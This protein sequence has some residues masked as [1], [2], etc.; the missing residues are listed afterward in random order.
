MSKSMWFKLQEAIMPKS[1]IKTM[2]A[3]GNAKFATYGQPAGLWGVVQMFSNNDMRQHFSAGV[4]NDIRGLNFNAGNTVGSTTIQSLGSPTSYGVSSSLVTLNLSAEVLFTNQ[5]NVGMRLELYVIEPRKDVPASIASGSIP[6]NNLLGS[7]PGQVTDINSSQLLVPGGVNVL[8]GSDSFANFDNNINEYQQF[9]LYYKVI[10][11][12]KAIVAGGCGFTFK[13]SFTPRYKSKKGSE[14]W[15]G[16][17]VS[18]LGIW[19]YKNSGRSII[20]RVL[21]SQVQY[22]NTATNAMAYPQQA[23]TWCWKECQ[24]SYVAS[25]TNSSRTFE[26]SQVNTAGDTLHPI[27]IINPLTGATTPFTVNI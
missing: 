26:G 19:E 12:K 3:G 25:G 23:V 13:H 7:K 16:A 21:P 8:G 1:I 11:C 15:Q 14:I 24:T 22:C 17:P 6:A 4:Y 9:N 27:T 10:S 18:G 5:T 20:W 2:W